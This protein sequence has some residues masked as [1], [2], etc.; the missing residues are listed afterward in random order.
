MSPARPNCPAR[1]AGDPSWC[2]R[3]IGSGSSV[4]RAW[5][6]MNSEFYRMGDPRSRDE[7]QQSIGE[8]AGCDT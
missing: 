7:Y 2:A 4:G 1:L 3:R 5:R 6:D 8:S